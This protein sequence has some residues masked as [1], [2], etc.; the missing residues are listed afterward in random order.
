MVIGISW[1]DGVSRQLCWLYHGKW[2]L[3][4]GLLVLLKV[5][6]NLWVFTPDCQCPERGLQEQRFGFL[7]FCSYFCFRKERVLLRS[8]SQ[9]IFHTTSYKMFWVRKTKTHGKMTDDF[10]FWG[11][12]YPNCRKIPIIFWWSLVTYCLQT[13]VL[14]FRWIRDV[15]FTIT[16]QL[17]LTTWQPVHVTRLTRPASWGL[18]KSLDAVTWIPWDEIWDMRLTDRL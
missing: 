13:L 8:F 18:P 3:L 14:T 2:W 4:S 15:S 7:C 16:K 11:L 6:L 12:P 17:N 10:L 9:N 1:S 5:P